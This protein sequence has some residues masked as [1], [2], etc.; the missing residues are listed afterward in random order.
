VRPGR[1]VPFIRRP[2]W[3]QCSLDRSAYRR[4]GWVV[5]TSVS[6]TP[7][8]SLPIVCAA[9]H[10]SLLT[11]AGGCA[12]QVH[13]SIGTLRVL[14]WPGRWDAVQADGGEGLAGGLDELGFGQ[15][16]RLADDVD[17]ALVELPVAA[18]LRA[19]GTPHRPDLERAERAGQ[20]G[21][22]AAVEPGQRHRQVVAQAEVHEVARA[23]PGLDQLGKAAAEYLEDELLVLAPWPPWSRVMSSSASISIRW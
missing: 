15:D 6:R 23:G 12:D 3:A 8:W 17:V 16:A 4:P 19:F 1:V 7:A 18:L 2:H 21:V 22:V 10:M 9:S 13:S 5:G 14:R 20:P 11:R